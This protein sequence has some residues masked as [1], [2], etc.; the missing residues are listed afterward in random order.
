[1]TPKS[2]VYQFSI[3]VSDVDRSLYHDEKLAVALHPSESVEFMMTRLIAWCLEYGEGIA[4]SRGIGAPDEPTISI[5]ELDGVL[6]LWVEIG[7]PSTERLHRAAKAAK[8]VSVYCHRS[9]EQVYQQLSRESIFNGDQIP[10]Y[11]FDE[12]FITGLCAALD[13]R[14]ELSLSH[15]EGVLYVTLNRVDLTSTLQERRLR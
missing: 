5:K 2:T 9:A 10:F 3:Q 12:G 1:M 7:A 15:T 13:R 4:F 8:R 6:A 14:N 11:S